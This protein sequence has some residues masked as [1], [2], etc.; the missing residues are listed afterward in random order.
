MGNNLFFDLDAKKRNLKIGDVIKILVIFQT[1]IPEF[2]DTLYSSANKDTSFWKLVLSG[3]LKAVR[4]GQN[5]T[6][7]SFILLVYGNN[8]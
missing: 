1:G 3:F 4:T 7:F 6:K 8:L 5:R 2:W